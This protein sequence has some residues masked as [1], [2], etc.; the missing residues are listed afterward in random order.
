MTVRQHPEQVT[1]GC[2]EVYRIGYGRLQGWRLYGRPMIPGEPFSHRW[3][4][5][6][7]RRLTPDS[8]GRRWQAEAS[9]VCPTLPAKRGW[10]RTG[11]IRRMRRALRRE[12]GVW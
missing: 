9:D 8:L 10:T 11:A 6:R 2:P 4:R 12:L 5:S 3:R 1:A 7:Y